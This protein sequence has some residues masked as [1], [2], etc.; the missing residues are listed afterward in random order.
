MQQRPKK[1]VSANVIFS[2]LAGLA[3]LFIGNAQA[4]PVYQPPG[5]NLTYGD[6]THGQRVLS[7]VTNPAAAAAEIH[8]SED[9]ARTGTLFSLG[10]GLEYGNV[11]G[12]FDLIDKVSAGIEPSDPEAGEPPS[13]PAPALVAA[14]T[15]HFP[16]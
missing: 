7:A 2:S 3:T 9:K 13:P 1:L 4:A 11:D 15:T 14:S 10:A 12:L 8:R 6:V 5:S 16:S